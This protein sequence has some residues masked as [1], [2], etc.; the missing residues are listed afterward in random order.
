M[1]NPKRG[2]GRGI[3]ALIMTDDAAGK[4]GQD[5]VRM[6]DIQS[7][8]PDKTQPR[9]A[10]EEEA[11]EELADSVRVHGIIEPLL[12]QEKGDFYQI[13]AGER[14]FRAAKK[15]GLTKIP[16]LVKEYTPQEVLEVSLIEN[17]QREDLN[18]LEEA[19]AFE[20]LLK[21]YKLKQDEVARKVGKSRSAV[22]NSVRLLSLDDTVQG[23]VASGA[24][25][26]GHAKVLLSVSS[27]TKQREAAK[28]AVE[29]G[30]SVRALESYLRGSSNDPK[31]SAKEGLEGLSSSEKAALK[32]AERALEA[33][34]GTKV[35]ISGKQQS[36]HLKG[37]IEIAYYSDDELERLID[38]LERG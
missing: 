14:R 16:V 35:S 11:L 26:T 23:Y 17:L 1:A 38:L 21:E 8:L 4:D 10:F 12:V 37:K 19:K 31:G 6:I 5:A 13:I 3:G 7:I 24:L 32:Q 27:R 30:W 28:K 15:A 20:R 33:A 34:L 9:K 25:S 18:P 36:G 2:L 22:A 29:R